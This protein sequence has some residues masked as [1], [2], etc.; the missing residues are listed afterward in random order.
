MQKIRASTYFRLIG[1]K[2]PKTDFLVDINDKV[3]ANIIRKVFN[4]RLGKNERLGIRNYNIS[5]N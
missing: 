1:K 5:K 3:L 2:K 4:I